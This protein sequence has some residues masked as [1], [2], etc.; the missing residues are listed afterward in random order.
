MQADAVMQILPESIKSALETTNELI[1]SF[2][3]IRI[4]I[5]R[6]IVLRRDNVSWYLKFD[7]GL[8]RKLVDEEEGIILSRKE[9]EQILVRA[10]RFS[11]YAA[12]QQIKEGYITIQGGHRIGICGEVM[13]QDGNI[14]GIRNIYSYNIRIAHEVRGCA[15]CIYPFLWKNER[16]LNTLI[17]SPPGCGKTT[18]LRDLLRMISDGDDEHPALT[19]CIADERGE[20]AACI[21]AVPQND[22]GKNTDV[23]DKGAKTKTLSLMLRSMSPQ[24]IA[25]DEAG[26]QEDIET[27]LQAKKWGVGI[28]TTVHGSINHN[29]LSCEH[30]ERVFERYVEIENV[31][32]RK[33]IVYDEGKNILCES[34]CKNDISGL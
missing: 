16:L 14:C 2:E 31:T 4:R 10:S 1:D 5:K 6:P 33:Y 18:L 32:K 34:V 12:Q 19:V 28:V 13:E 26:N 20:I 11:V 21:D 17:I 7:G 8:K 27:F 30:N 9:M 3:E 29:R 24:V 23:M 15:E 25:A 22:I